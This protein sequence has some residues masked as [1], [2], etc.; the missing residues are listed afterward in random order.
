MLLFLF[1]AFSLFS[2]NLGIKEFWQLFLGHSSLIPWFLRIDFEP[3]VQ[4]TFSIGIKNVGTT[5]LVPLPE[6]FATR[7]C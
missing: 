1:C 6:V 4:C 2:K 5:L 7:H 3:A